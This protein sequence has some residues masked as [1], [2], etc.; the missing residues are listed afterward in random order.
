MAQAQMSL[1][2]KQTY[3]QKLLQIIEGKLKCNIWNREKYDEILEL[4]VKEPQKEDK[5]SSY[6]YLV[7]KYEV[8]QCGDVKKIVKNAKI[9]SEEHLSDLANMALNINTDDEN[10]C[11]T[12]DEQMEISEPQPTEPKTDMCVVCEATALNATSCASCNKTVHVLCGKSIITEDFLSKVIC[13]LCDT[14][15]VIEKE[16]ANASESMVKQANYM[17]SRSY[18]V[19][20]EVDIGWHKQADCPSFEAQNKESNSMPH[21]NESKSSSSSQ[22]DTDSDESNT[23]SIDDTPEENMHVAVSKSATK[24]NPKKLSN[25]LGKAS[26]KITKETF[27]F[28]NKTNDILEEVENPKKKKKKTTK[29]RKKS[30]DATAKKSNIQTTMFQFGAGTPDSRSEK[31]PATTPTDEVHER[32]VPIQKPKGH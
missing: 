1:N 8:L 23:E 32:S 30:G 22:S 24:V 9:D 16:R 4:I 31:R 11:T 2:Q 14:E 20:E 18:R 7:K 19:L 12:D 13:S 26:K 25:V 27:S 6:Y 10:I 28:E 5:T 21:E 3:T 29:R 17:L 15:T